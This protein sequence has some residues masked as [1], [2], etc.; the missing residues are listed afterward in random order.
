MTGT[1][2][3]PMGAA[4]VR[5]MTGIVAKHMTSSP[6]AARDSEV[7]PPAM[8]ELGEFVI[9]HADWLRAL[10][11]VVD[12]SSHLRATHLRVTPEREQELLSLRPG[13]PDQ[14]EWR[15]RLM[16]ACATA[17]FRIWYEDYLRGA[18][19]DPLPRL[20]EMVSVAIVGFKNEDHQ[21]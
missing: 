8:H 7:I 21:S 2:A 5:E 6:A 13:Q 17:A 1:P 18:F 3:V 12:Q 15:R 19:P 9:A 14:P 10:S 4:A 11:R 16:F 20:D